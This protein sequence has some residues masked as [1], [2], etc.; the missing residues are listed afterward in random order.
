MWRYSNRSNAVATVP[1][2]LDNVGGKT[3]TMVFS[4]ETG[5]DVIMPQVKLSS[6]SVPLG[7]YAQQ[8]STPELGDGN[9]IPASVR[10]FKPTGLSPATPQVSRNMIEVPPPAKA[11]VG[12][13]QDWKYLDAT[14]TDQTA[15]AYLKS[16]TQ[17]SDGR[18]INIWVQGSE[19]GTNPATQITQVMADQLAAKF[20]NGSNSVYSLVTTL[21]GQPW[22]PHPYS[23]LIPATSK[24]INIV[25]VNF[26][27]DGKAGGLLGYFYAR[28]NFTTASQPKSNGALAFFIDSE[29]LY[30]GGDTGVKAI[31]STLAHEFVHMI[32]FYRRGVL[33]GSD[34]IYDTWLEEMTAMMMEDAI[35][36]K[37]D[38]SYNPIRDSRFPGWLQNG[39]YNCALTSW[40][41]NNGSNCFSYSIAG[42]FGGFLLR[43]YGL[44]FYLTLLNSAVS[45][46]SVR[47]VDASI[48]VNGGLGFSD[49]FRRWGT[50]IALMP[51]A[52]TPLS[53]GY[54]A[55]SDNGGLMT[56]PALNGPDYTSMRAAGLPKVL[57]T[58]LKAYS[59]FPVV[60]TN[61]AAT[62]SENVTVPPGTTLSVIVN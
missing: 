54:P 45:T 36:Q 60:R 55:R 23:N 41:D 32:N 13:F 11:V 7:S 51:A 43:Q 19:F 25:V 16:Q 30:K 10:G 28:N 9:A 42:S 62:Y 49:A 61:L 3:L 24:D 5:A 31:T 26:A 35:S 6:V 14:D 8:K 33:L 58:T 20:G 2:T 48:R 46:D 37:L 12:D 27:P 44:N 18:L 56:L 52:G 57:P 34:F 21:A 50:S 29:T 22:G 47:L 38:P 40:N 1:V 59:H 53:F 15:R 17:T 39:G 4:N